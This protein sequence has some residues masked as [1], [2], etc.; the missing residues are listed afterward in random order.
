MN[1]IRVTKQ[2]PCPVCGKPNWCMVGE[3]WVICMRISSK[4]TKNFCDGSK[5]WLHPVGETAHKLSPPTE[6][7]PVTLDVRTVLREWGRHRRPGAMSLL[8]S[9]L[10]V[11]LE[12]L[13]LLGCTKAP[14]HGTWA[15][16]MRTGEGEFCGIRLRR[17][18]GDKW[19]ERGSHQGLFIPQ[20]Q[21]SPVIL[22]CEG[23]TDTAAALTLGYSAAG[24]PNCCGGIQ[25]LQTLV[26]RLGV[27]MAVIVADLDDAGLR[28]AKT[29]QEHLPIATAVLVLPAKDLR[30]AVRAGID[31]ATMDAMISTLVWKRP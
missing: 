2:H 6:R 30:S 24:R 20:A 16:P 15:F 23:P 17:D 31:R 14:I 7:K 3:K 12:S 21:F 10:G 11:T 29:L 26:A 25:Q 4:M 13:E 27:R 28:G 8:A 22:I 9:D 18:N 1:P 19:A 5:G